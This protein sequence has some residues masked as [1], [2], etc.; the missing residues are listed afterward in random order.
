[1]KLYSIGLTVRFISLPHFLF[2]RDRNDTALTYLGSVLIITACRLLGEYFLQSDMSFV[3]FP[4][5][6]WFTN[7]VGWLLWRF[8]FTAQL[9]NS[10]LFSDRQ[11]C[12]QMH[13]T[14]IVLWLT[15]PG[16]EFI[17]LSSVS[18]LVSS[19]VRPPSPL[20][21]QPPLWLLLSPFISHSLLQ[22]TYVCVY[23]HAHM[24]WHIYGI[25][26]S[27]KEGYLWI[28]WN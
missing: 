21:L 24:M 10:A 17:S 28:G 15:S 22:I 27:P 23:A 3:F 25:C 11:L 1:M 9:I 5:T 6:V 14:A 2:D 20:L 26:L 4:Q 8:F 16:E 13:K 7:P 12:P 19:L 18:F